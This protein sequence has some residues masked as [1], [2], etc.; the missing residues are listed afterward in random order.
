MVELFLLC[1]GSAGFSDIGQ[2]ECSVQA[3]QGCKEREYVS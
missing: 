3:D 1:G 2:T